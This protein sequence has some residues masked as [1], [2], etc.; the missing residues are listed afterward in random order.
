MQPLCSA[1][2]LQS[3]ESIVERAGFSLYQILPIRF[4]SENPSSRLDSDSTQPSLRL[5]LSP[6]KDRP[7]STPSCFGARCS[8][9]GAGVVTAVVT[10]IIRLCPGPGVHRC[11][12]TGGFVPARGAAAASSKRNR[13]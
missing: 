13:M 8:W 10:Q 2:A 4:E 12:V 7:S 3:N 1:A 9:T 5:A 6:S 11:G